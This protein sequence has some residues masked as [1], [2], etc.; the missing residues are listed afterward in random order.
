MTPARHQVATLPLGHS[1][2]S[3]HPREKKGHHSMNG[4]LFHSGCLVVIA[5]F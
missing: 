5:A 3:G 4:G 2:F 1:P